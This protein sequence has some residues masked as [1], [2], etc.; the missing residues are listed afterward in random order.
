MRIFAEQGIGHANHSEVAVAAG[1]SLPTLFYHYPDHASLTRAVLAKV[2]HF[3]L[4]TIGRTAI[5]E[6]PGGIDA[7]ERIL[8]RLANALDEHRDL[9]RIWLDWST[10]RSSE[11]WSEYLEFNDKAR[12]LVEPLVAQGQKAGEADLELDISTA[13]RVVVGMA[14]MVAQMSLTSRPADEI[15]LAVH[16]LT[17]GLFRPAPAKKDSDVVRK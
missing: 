3:L 13:S 4:D 5:E 9:I 11:A 16:R 12:H 7:I 10:A 1:V 2:S 8:L 15:E 14:H 17:R 6:G